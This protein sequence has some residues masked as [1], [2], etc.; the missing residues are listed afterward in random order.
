MVWRFQKR[1]RGHFNDPSRKSKRLRP[2]ILLGSFAFMSH[3]YSF[4]L[5]FA[6][7]FPSNPAFIKFKN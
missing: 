5:V 6:A 1:Q 3:F 2:N 4:F 7:F